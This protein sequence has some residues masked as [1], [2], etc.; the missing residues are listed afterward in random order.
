MADIAFELTYNGWSGDGD[1]L[2]IK[3]AVTLA[4]EGT[5]GHAIP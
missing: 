3:I 5:C 2:A 1:R 4:L